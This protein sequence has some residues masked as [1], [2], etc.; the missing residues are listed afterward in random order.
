[1]E[2]FIGCDAHKKFSV[3]IAMNSEGEYGRAIRVGHDREQMRAFLLSLPAGSQ[4]ALE[5]SRSYYWRVE[6]MERA[7]HRATVSTSPDGEAADGRP[8]QDRRAGHARASNVAAKRNLAGRV[9]SAG[10]T[11]RSARDAALADVFS[12]SASGT[13]EP[14]SRYA[15]TV[16]P[17]DPGQ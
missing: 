4:I 3:F 11:A 7:G 1:M 8:A 13:E 5:A 12:T 16:Q 6:E 15:I 17:A 2:Q 10:G 9:D 14:H